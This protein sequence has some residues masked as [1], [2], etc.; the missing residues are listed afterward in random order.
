MQV[1]VVHSQQAKL[2]M[3]TNLGP[4]QVK[5]SH[6]WLIQIHCVKKMEKRILRKKFNIW[7]KMEGVVH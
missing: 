3:F 5:C 2:N 1:I 6:R 7:R 4:Y